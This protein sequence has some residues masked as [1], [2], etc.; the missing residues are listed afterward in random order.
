MSGKWKYPTHYIGADGKRYSVRIY[1]TWCDMKRRCYHEYNNKYHIYG[2][3]G[4]TVCD[5]WLSYNA[6]Y[7]WAMSSGYEDTLTIDRIDVNGNYEPN[8]CRWA[9]VIT[10]AN[11]KRNNIRIEGLSLTDISNKYNIPYATLLARHKRGA[12][13]VQELIKSVRGAK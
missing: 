10:Q 7:E 5:D 11:N 1:R 3:R 9:D 13:T 6:F 8:N 12:R 4:I 2:A